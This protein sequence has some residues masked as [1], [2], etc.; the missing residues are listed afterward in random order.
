MSWRDAID[1]LLTTEDLAT[2]GAIIKALKGKGYAV[3]QATVSRHLASV[4]ADKVD[5]FYR[6]PPPPEIGAPIYDIVAA[7]GGCMVVV[8]TAPAHASVVAHAIDSQLTH[9][10]ACSGVL[11]TIAGDDTVFVALAEP[12]AL[13]DLQRLLGWTA[14]NRRQP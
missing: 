3:T 10:P 7:G 4:G 11:G 12:S 14:G 2:Q 8:R 6:L 9:N 1:D 13:A 5:G